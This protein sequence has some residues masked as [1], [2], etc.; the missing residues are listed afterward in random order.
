MKK[1]LALVMT[2]LLMLSLAA[3][4]KPDKQPV[5]DSY[6]AAVTAFDEVA[7]L[8]NENVDVV[9]PDL[10]DAL[11][12]MGDKLI[13]Y[14]ELLDSDLNQE[15]LDEAA[16]FLNTIPE[17]MQEVKNIIEEDLANLANI[18]DLGEGQEG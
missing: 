18:S 5:L 8:V 16:S 9:D 15:Q 4:G 11:N 2:A 13:T 17:K 6:N 10:I 12:Q 1:L 7:N 14:K 3:C